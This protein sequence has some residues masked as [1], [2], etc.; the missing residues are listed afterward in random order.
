M[1][2]RFAYVQP[3]LRILYVEEIKSIPCTLIS[4]PFV[5]RLIGTIRQEFFDHVLFWNVVDLER[6]V[7]DF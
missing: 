2:W 7:E 6:K 4:H 3:N 5:E 1:V